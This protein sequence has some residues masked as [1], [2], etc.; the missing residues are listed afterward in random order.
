MLKDKQ[1]NG[2]TRKYIKSPWIRGWIRSRLLQN[3]ITFLF[4]HPKDNITQY[5][6]HFYRRSLWIWDVLD[7]D[8]LQSSQKTEN[9]IHMDFIPRITY[10]VFCLSFSY[11]KRYAKFYPKKLTWNILKIIKYLL[12]FAMWS[13]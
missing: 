6:W 3:E 7:L 11:L 2:S 4:N 9:T 8:L 10:Y 12:P 1:L 5:L 13:I